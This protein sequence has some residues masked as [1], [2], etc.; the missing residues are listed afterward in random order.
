M[1]DAENNSTIP[2]THAADMDNDLTGE[3]ISISKMKVWRQFENIWK[4]INAFSKEILP[5]YSS[6][7]RRAETLSTLDI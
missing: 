3:R 2:Q 1:T 6:S 7:C 4:A 5:L